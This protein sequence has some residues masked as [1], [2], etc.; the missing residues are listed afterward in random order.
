MLLSGFFLIMII[1]DFEFNCKILYYIEE[2]KGKVSYLIFYILFKNN[3]FL[4]VYFIGKLFFG[5]VIFFSI[6]FQ[7][8]MEEGYFGF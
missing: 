6:Y 2:K 5:E 1:Q 4:N 8:N 7:L 3:F